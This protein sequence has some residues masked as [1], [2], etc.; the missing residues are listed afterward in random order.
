[1]LLAVLLALSSR[2]QAQ[3]VK[4]ASQTAAELA[5][6][7]DQL[8][9]RTEEQ[10]QYT[11]LLEA[12]ALISGELTE[13]LEQE[14][15]LRRAVA[16]IGERLHM[17]RAVIYRADAPGGEV[18]VEAMHGAGPAQSDRAHES[19]VQALRSSTAQ[20]RQV[21]RDEGARQELML[22]FGIE[23]QCAG[24]LEMHAPQEEPF[25]DREVAAL[26]A[27][28]DQLAVAIENAGLYSEARKSLR[29]LDAIQR[30]YTA[31][32]W[33]RFSRSGAETI[34]YQLG[35]GALADEEWHHVFE[36]AR[37]AGAPVAGESD[38]EGGHHL[39]AVPVKLRNLPIG[40]LG[41]HRPASAGSWQPDEIAAIVTVTDR[42]ALAIENAR[43]LEGA[44][45]R[46]AQEQALNRMVARFVRSLDMDS[47]L[48]G[49]VR[50]IGH[51]LGLDEVSVHL[52]PPMLGRGPDAL[53]D[54]GSSLTKE[55]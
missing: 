42:L 10:E 29:E 33:Q 31:E 46:A 51:E 9:T 20:Q 36:Q 6:A 26:Q 11:G 21:D 32:A 38:G 52:A 27:M 24:V 3:A 47:L 44:Q 1:V 7:H 25:T 4:R 22:P 15:V 8:Q 41:F 13:L 54:D 17:S 19:V 34:R 55:S 14:V 39:L 43:L 40:V 18:T 30:Q 5:T 23:G 35:S 2:A 53:P 16:L 45:L 50:E 49:A 28:A 37:S 48:Q 12:T